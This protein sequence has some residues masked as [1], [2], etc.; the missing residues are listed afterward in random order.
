ME[1]TGL[2]VKVY[3]DVILLVNFIMDF[4]FILWA[5]GK[6]SNLPVKI[7]RLVLGA[8][9]GALYSIAVLLPQWSFLAHF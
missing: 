7:S 5:T 3:L 1:E 9:I 8:F 2:T 4:F 6:L